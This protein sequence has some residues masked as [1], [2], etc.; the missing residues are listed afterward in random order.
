MDYLE[1]KNEKHKHPRPLPLD[2]VT[3]EIELFVSMNI[4]KGYQKWEKYT[5][6]EITSEWLAA[7]DIDA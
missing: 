1:R 7:L 6:E 2:W 4:I 3:S 5:P